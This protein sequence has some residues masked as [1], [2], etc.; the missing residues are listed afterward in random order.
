M[1][2]RWIL[3]GLERI[4]HVRARS[5]APRDAIG[6]HDRINEML[7]EDGKTARIQTTGAVILRFPGLP[8]QSE[9]IVKIKGPAS[10]S[11]YLYYLTEDARGTVKARLRVPTQTDKQRSV[12]ATCDARFANELKTLL[13]ETIRVVGTA[14]WRRTESEEWIP[15][16][17][18]ITDAKKIEIRGLKQAVES[19]RK[20]NA[21]WV[22]NPIAFQRNYDNDENGEPQ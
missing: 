2:F 21:G 14:D 1:E 4:D 11:G 18:H 7:A 19:L 5:D 16:S 6:A 10:L 8:D 17:V 3:E 13:F 22:D 15:S 9:G 20:V 12:D